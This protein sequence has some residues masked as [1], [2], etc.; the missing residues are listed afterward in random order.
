MLVAW[1][2]S[3][4]AAMALRSAMP[5]LQ[6][7]AEVQVLIVRDR[8]DDYPSDSA[9]RYLGRHGIEPEI[10]Q[11]PVGD[12]IGSAISAAGWEL[13]AGPIVM[14]ACGYSRLRHSF[15]AAQPGSYCN[16]PPCPCCWPTE[17]LGGENKI[18]PGRPSKVRLAP[19][20]PLDAVIRDLTS[21]RRLI[22][23]ADGNF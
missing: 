5:L 8:L 9:A 17:Q 14:G 13:G 2:G 21:G 15:S 19:R 1:N 3:P 4:E 22:C 23:G 16:P 6:L 11:R 7:A 18:N 10:V 20:R 12:G